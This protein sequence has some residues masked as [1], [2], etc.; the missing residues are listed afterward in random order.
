MKTYNHLYINR[1]SHNEITTPIYSYNYQNELS[2]ETKR[3]KKD[4]FCILILSTYFIVLSIIFNVY[5]NYPTVFPEQN[6]MYFIC[7]WF[8]FIIIPFLIDYHTNFYLTYFLA[9]FNILIIV[10]DY[11]LLVRLLLLA[12]G[13][14]CEITIGVNC[15][16]IILQEMRRAFNSPF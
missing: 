6:L 8:I 3:Y 13:I 15:S 7:C 4:K 1:I 14:I 16:E 10:F 5:K 11:L 9:G 12:A 2:E